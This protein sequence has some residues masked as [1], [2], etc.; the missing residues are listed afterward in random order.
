[1]L[2]RF[3][4]INNM[5]RFGAGL[6]IGV[7]AGRSQLDY[8]SKSGPH[9]IEIGPTLIGAIGCAFL[10]Y[11]KGEYERPALLSYASGYSIGFLLTYNTSLQEQLHQTLSYGM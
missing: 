5:A 3:F 2:T 11:K 1:M 6:M 4:T 9:V 10:C 8:E 7:A